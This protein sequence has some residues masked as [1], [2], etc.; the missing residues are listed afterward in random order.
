MTDL[1]TADV[2]IIGGGIMGCSAALALA[3]QGLRVTLL[4][5]RQCGSQASGVNFG[6]V[7][8]QGRHLEELPL[9]MRARDIWRQLSSLLGNDCEYRRIGHLRLARTDAHLRELL[10]YQARARDYGLALQVIDG[11][12]LRARYPWLAPGLAGASLASDDGHANPRLVTPYFAVT[13]RRHGARILEQQPVKRVAFDGAQFHIETDTLRLRARQLINAAGAWGAAIARDL[14]ETV[15]LTTIYPNM[16]VTEPVGAWMTHCLGVVGGGFYARQ[17]P[18]GNIV[19][20]GRRTTHNTGL[21]PA[22]PQASVTVDTLRAASAC[23]PAIGRLAVIRT[24]T[25]IEGYFSDTL[26][27]LGPSATTPGAWHA[28]GFSGHGFQLG[29]A[30]GEVL[31][32]LVLH[33]DSATPISPFAITRFAH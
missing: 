7:R 30:V 14:G 4:E 2:A 17:V 31:A 24:W 22:R 25:G 15:P 13:A 23:V 32:D 16:L 5:A 8:Q 18:R 9:S 6:G 11:A 3:R 12:T 10:Q 27:V 28:F 29:P 26:P 20:G 19:I 33:G 1:D 21:A